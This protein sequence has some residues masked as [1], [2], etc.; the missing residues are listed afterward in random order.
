MESVGETSPSLEHVRR[1]FV[2]LHDLILHRFG[3]KLSTPAPL[4]VVDFR[5]C[6]DPM[7]SHVHAHEVVPRG[8]DRGGVRCTTIGAVIIWYL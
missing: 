7:I 2:V 1:P 8:R 5:L 4:P 3:S 6:L